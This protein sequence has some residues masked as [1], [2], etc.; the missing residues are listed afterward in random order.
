[1]TTEPKPF[2]PKTTPT[3][4]YGGKVWPLAELGARQLRMVRV[5]LKKLTDRLNTALRGAGADLVKQAGMQA[6][7][8]LTID[9]DEYDALML[10]PIWQ[11]ITRLHP[12]LTWD[13]FL[14]LPVKDGEVTAAWFAA[15]KISGVFEF[16]ESAKTEDKD[17]Q[18]EAQAPVEAAPQTQNGTGTTS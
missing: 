8:L 14:D 3:L 6:D 16:V 9:G 18:G 17:E 2:D 1:M 12:D 15:R 4:T 11:A 7:I 13:E 5:P 10:V